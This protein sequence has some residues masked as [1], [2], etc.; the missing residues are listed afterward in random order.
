MNFLLY[1]D[2]GLRSMSPE[3]E[4]GHGR[5]GLFHAFWCDRCKISAFFRHCC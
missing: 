4:H 1:L 5:S 3:R 2:S